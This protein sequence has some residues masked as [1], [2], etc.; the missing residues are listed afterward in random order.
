M[1]EALADPLRWRLVVELGRSDLRAGELARLVERPQ[2]LVSYHLAELRRA[3]LVSA[4]RSSADRRDVY[5]RAELA[6]CR[7]LLAV[8]GGSLHPYVA[9]PARPARRA[10]RRPRV[11]FLCTGDSARSQIAEA[12]TR[13]RSG[14]AVTAESAGS[15][16]KPLHPLAVRV[17]AERG[18]D[19]SGH[20]SKHLDRFTRR[21]FDRVVTLCDKAREVCPDF[22]GAPHVHWSVPDPASRGDLET[23]D[24]AFDEVADE[25]DLRVSAL[26]A[27]F[28]IPT[29]REER[30]CPT[31]PRSA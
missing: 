3:G 5:Y 24:R 29:T 17:L 11:L 16:P 6:R 20:S 25:I 19:A 31:P 2:N 26:L 18:I 7:E 21:R 4:R 30:P 27:E 12:L 1:F 23:L 9:A 14:G 28:G 13:H 8:A 22:A 15:H 10:H